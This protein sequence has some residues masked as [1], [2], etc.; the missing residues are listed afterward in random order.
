[1]AM[2]TVC[3]C[4]KPVAIL[5]EKGDDVPA[6]LF[7]KQKTVQVFAMAHLKAD[8]QAV[9]THLLRRGHRK[10]AYCSMYHR[11]K[12]S[13]RRMQGLAD[14]FEMAGFPGAIL[15]CTAALESEWELVP[16]LVDV[17][18]KGIAH[19]LQPVYAAFN[20]LERELPLHLAD[21]VFDLRMHTGLIESELELLK[22]V[23]PLFEKAHSDRQCTAWVCG[24]DQLALNALSFC[25]E[26]G[27]A[28]PGDVSIIGF[29][30]TL[31]ALR[32]NLSSYNFAASV[33]VRRML[34]FIL[35]NNGRSASARYRPVE[36][37]GYITE[38]G[39]TGVRRRKG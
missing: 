13:V 14:S 16:E 22:L 7:A 5:D 35:R 23:R 9:G 6:E 24:N 11:N 39:T 19:R 10:A 20:A 2:C 3:G 25:A 34:D 26:K 37:Q 36:I 32:R 1:M 31:E 18:R 38:R 21:Q 15:E 8:G 4:G 28:V 30:D 33:Y 27:I 29:D 17:P 12:W